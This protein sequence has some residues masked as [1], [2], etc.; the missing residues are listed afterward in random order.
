MPTITP[1]QKQAV[2]QAG[3]APVPIT[4]PESDTSF[5]LL[6]ADVYERMLAAAVEE[7]D[8]REG[9]PVVDRIMAI[10]DADD[11]YLHLYQAGS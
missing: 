10:D 4:D 6:K 9:Y 3:D 2:D 1:E 5:V 8:P 7:A 11:P